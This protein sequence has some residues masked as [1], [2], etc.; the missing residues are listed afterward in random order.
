MVC[1]FFMAKYEL[2]PIETSY[3]RRGL[4][5]GG[6]SLNDGLPLR[7]L[8]VGGAQ[9]QNFDRSLGRRELLEEM[10]RGY[11]KMQ[12]PQLSYE[13][14]EKKAYDESSLKNVVPLTPYQFGKQ[15]SLI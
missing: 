13:D 9:R 14:K 6:A 1:L 3:S 8:P 12:W 15:Y 10:S 7:P 11:G 2:K 4:A 5:F